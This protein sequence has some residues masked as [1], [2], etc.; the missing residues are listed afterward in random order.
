[1]QYTYM[2]DKW[3]QHGTSCNLCLQ[4]GFT[5]ICRGIDHAHRVKCKLCQTWLPRTCD[6][7][8][9][10]GVSRVNGT[11]KSRYQYQRSDTW[12]VL[13]RAHQNVRCHRM[14][15]QRD[16]RL[17][18]DSVNY[19]F[20]LGHQPLCCPIQRG[21]ITTHGFGMLTMTLEIKCMDG[22]PGLRQ[23][24]RIRLHDLP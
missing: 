4:H 14:S 15:K 6:K 19:V 24:K 16:W 2:L 8:Q 17:T 20:R 1:M 10:C 3:R 22:I 7:Q 5:R 11:R 12:V 21:D 13:S 9:V 18:G 23:H